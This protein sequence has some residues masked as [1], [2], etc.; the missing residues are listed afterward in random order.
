MQET[1]GAGKD[2]EKGEPSYTVGRN[3]NWC[4][5]SGK[6]YRDTFKN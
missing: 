5:H 6:Q 3:A 1:T 4:G 2:V